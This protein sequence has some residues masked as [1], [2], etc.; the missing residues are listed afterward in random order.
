MVIWTSY[1]HHTNTDCKKN[2]PPAVDRQQRQVE[3]LS[4]LQMARHSRTSL[5][6]LLHRW[7]DRTSVHTQTKSRLACLCV[8]LSPSRHPLP[9][10]RHPLSPSR[11]PLGPLQLSR[12]PL[13]CPL[14]KETVLRDSQQ[15]GLPHSLVVQVAP[16]RPP[17]PSPPVVLVTQTPLQLRQRL[18]PLVVVILVTVV[19]RRWVVRGDTPGVTM[20]LTS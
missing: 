1:Q 17:S 14:L 2:T 15:V 7:Q 13:P 16:K 18:S 20:Q 11:H 8:P 9:P 10:S 12:C 3:P 19:R 6:K 4:I 5:F